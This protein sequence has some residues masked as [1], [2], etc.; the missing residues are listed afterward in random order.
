[1]AATLGFLKVSADCVSFLNTFT[2]CCCFWSVTFPVLKLSPR[3]QIITLSCPIL[4][5]AITT[6][7]PRHCPHSQTLRPDTKV[8]PSTPI[9][10]SDLEPLTIQLNGGSSPWHSSAST[11][12]TV[13]GL[14]FLCLL[15]LI[16]EHCNF[17]PP[18]CS[19]LSQ[20]SQ[21]LKV[22]CSFSSKK[23]SFP[24][25]FHCLRYQQPSA[26]SFSPQ[27]SF[28][29][30]GLLPFPCS[31]PCSAGEG[32][33]HSDEDEGYPEPW[34]QLSGASQFPSVLPLVLGQLLPLF[35]SAAPNHYHMPQ[36]PASQ[37]QQMT[38]LLF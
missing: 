32:K 37:S 36:A 4:F 23:L 14:N 35:P 11:P 6:T 30:E 29:A 3:C 38:C 7:A 20:R 22:S 1:M 13:H 24:G 21:E 31:L 8:F 17:W 34:V 27:P 9:P 2:H 12:L 28:F 15:G 19:L 25:S 18:A 10:A 16:F 26:P 5:T 33:S